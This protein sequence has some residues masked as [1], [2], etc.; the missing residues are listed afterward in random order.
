M[1]ANWH[2]ILFVCAILWP[3]AAQAE[4]PTA[5]PEDA[6]A[7]TDEQLAVVH[8]KVE[9]HAEDLGVLKAAADAA[10]KLKLSGYVQGRFEWHQDS[11]DGLDSAGKPA[12]TTGFLVRRGRLKALYA[13]DHSEYLLQ[14]DATGKGVVLKDAEASVLEP[15]SPLGLKFTLGQFKVPF[16]YEIVQSSS[17]R[18][19]PE[20]S[21]VVKTLFPGERDRGLRVTGKWNVLRLALAVVN[22]NGIEDAIYTANDQNAY[23]DMVGRV[24]VDLKFEGVSVVLGASGYSGRGLKTTSATAAKLTG[25]DANGDGKI[26]GDEITFTPG[27]AASWDRYD[28]TRMGGDLQLYIDVP[29]LGG[30]AVKGEI[31]ASTDTY[32]GTGDTPADATKDVKGQGWSALLVQNVGMWGQVVVRADKWDPNTNKDNDAVTTVG[33][34]VLWRASANARLALIYE[35][36]KLEDTTAAA[37]SPG[38][39]VLTMQLQGNF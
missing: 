7:T 14:L 24:G 2:Q 21:R 31:I 29:H 20:R 5:R 32:L 12:D 34:G 27:T 16:G 15:W 28:R 38:L 18:E 26:I 22:G 17:E 30:L 23:K 1:L 39:D 9:G 11:K 37:S 10:A 33:G 8:G 25:K 19:M 4:E 3:T 13:G 6:T 36:P 35:H